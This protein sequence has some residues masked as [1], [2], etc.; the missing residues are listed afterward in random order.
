MNKQ[1]YT[2]GHYSVYAA[3][4]QTPVEGPHFADPLFSPFFGLGLWP[5]LCMAVQGLPF[6]YIN[7]IYNFK[8]ALTKFALG[9]SF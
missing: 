1:R 3:L 8:V 2:V 5:I 7:I 6:Y 4:L 9:L